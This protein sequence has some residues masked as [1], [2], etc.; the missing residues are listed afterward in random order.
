MAVG[1]T[2]SGTGYTRHF[3]GALHGS[4]GI[5]A[6][7]HLRRQIRGPFI[8]IGDRASIHQANKVREYLAGCPEIQVEWLPPYAPDLNP[9]EY[10]HENAKA[11]LKNATPAD[12]WEIRRLL[13]R[14]FARIRRHPDLILGF[15]HLAGLR[16][17]QLR[18]L[19]CASRERLTPAVGLHEFINLKITVF[20]RHISN[21][22]AIR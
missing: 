14:Q 11:H 7:A 6:L 4:Q 22:F 5:L 19:V 17:N 8:L 16:V 18:R 3:V 1:L 10:C 12:K 13:D 21:L 15:F 9:E 20:E 2:V